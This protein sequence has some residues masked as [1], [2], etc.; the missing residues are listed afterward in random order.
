MAY[1]SPLEEFAGKTFMADDLGIGSLEQVTLGELPASPDAPPPGLVN[2]DDLGLLVSERIEIRRAHAWPEPYGFTEPARACITPGGDYLMMCP[3]GESHQWGKTE[4]VNEIVAY[5]SSDKG[6]TWTGPVRPWEV[7][8]PQH[9]FN[10][11]I[12]PD[13][14]RIYTFGADYHIDY[15]QLPHASVLGMRYSDDD[16]HTWSEVARIEPAVDPGFRGV[17]HMQGCITH[18]GTWL[19]GSYDIP[20][21]VDGV[22]S[23]RQYVLRT[24]DEGAGWQ[25]LPDIRPNGWKWDDGECTSMMEGEI[26]QLADGEILMFT[27]VQEGHIWLTRSRDDGQTW[28]D[29]APTVMVHPFAPPMVFALANGQTLV[30]FTHNRCERKA[31]DRTEL[32][33]CVSKDSGHTW[34]EPRF[35]VM[36]SSGFG[37]REVSYADLI[38]DGEDLHMFF[39]H[40]KRQI[41]HAH[42]SESD[43]AEFPKIT[44]LG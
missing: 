7:P 23:D 12:P 21:P 18:A 10:P 9:A 29:P 28:T 26:L 2:R 39:D 42:S 14:K 6:R 43:L 38:V 30:S 17:F 24:E 1:N 34:S 19:L 31:T 41:I 25:I 22:R 13:G 8:Y 44:D 35:L 3:A 4:Q 40:G 33:A 5:R 27:R 11:L 15:V 37:N 20:K 36:D 16:G 32:W